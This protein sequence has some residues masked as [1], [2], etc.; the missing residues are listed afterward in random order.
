[1]PNSFKRQITIR[2]D[3]AAVDYFKKLAAELGMPSLFERLR[4]ADAASH[5]SVAQGRSEVARHQA[6]EQSAK[7]EAAGARTIWGPSRIG[8][9][10]VFYRR[11][12]PEIR[13]HQGTAP[14]K[15]RIRNTL[16]P[17]RV[18]SVKQDRHYIGV[19]K[20]GVHLRPEWAAGL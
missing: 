15:G 1:M 16:L 19:E 3:A 4:H 11:V 2:I 17:Q 14:L 8:T 20:Q 9:T 6:I 18:V 13:R 12:I 5:G 10:S 7:P